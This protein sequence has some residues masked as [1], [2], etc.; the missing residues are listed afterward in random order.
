MKNSLQP[1]WKDAP[2]PAGWSIDAAPRLRLALLFLAFAVPVCFTA[3]RLVWLQVMIPDRFLTTWIRTHESFE[4]IPASDGR[5]LARDGE[6]LAFDQPLYSIRVH[7]RWIEEPPNAVWLKARARETLSKSDRKNPE[8]VAEAQQQILEQRQRM[9]QTLSEL[10]GVSPAELSDKRSQVQARIEQ[11]AQQVNER[12]QQKK[13]VRRTSAGESAWRRI[14]HELS[15][16]PERENDNWIIVSEELQSHVIL[17]QVPVDQIATIEAQP[18]RFPGVEIESTSERVYPQGALAAHLIGW[19]SAVDASEIERRKL[20]FPQGDPLALEIGDRFGRSGVERT[21]DSQLRGV[22]GLKRVVRNYAGEIVETEV[23]TPPRNGV[24]LTLSIDAALQKQAE[25][26]L[27]LSL[28]ASPDHAQMPDSGLRIPPQAPRA[29]SIVVLDLRQGETWIAASAPSF[30]LAA[31]QHPTQ[32]QWKSWND[33]PSHPFVSRVTQAAVPPGSIFQIVT[34][35]AGLDNRLISPLS[36]FRCQGYLNEPTLDRCKHFLTTGHGHGDINLSMALAQSCHVYFFDLAQRMGPIPIE[37]WARQ[38]GFG[39]PTGI[40]VGGEKPGHVPTTIQATRRARQNSGTVKQLAI[41]QSDLTA[42]PLQVAKLMA[43]LGNGGHEITPRV[44][45]GQQGPGEVSSE[46]ELVKAS[47]T[48]GSI[49]S[50]TITA[51]QQGLEM[52]VADPRGIAH[53][54]HVD[55]VPMAGQAGIAEVGS[56]RPPHAWY[57]GYFPVDRPRYAIVT[58]LEH[59]GSEGAHAAATLARQVVLSLVEADLLKLD[60]G[61]E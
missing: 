21:Y 52:A 39:T 30:N 32:E 59:G 11:I 54:A 2:S 4:S 12:H 3:G 61:V 33:D 46:I 38:L 47:V 50:D 53:S 31:I 41:G 60:T 15:T 34:A 55:G 28:R 58:Y 9:W 24:D 13:A 44:T 5:V 51:I 49:T 6:V 20:R 48:P 45:L 43:I 16:P 29:G 10:T 35:I 17:S 27:E 37:A 57:C 19:R 56:R 7:Y 26:L 8:R 40:D 18:S 36:Q 25:D 14:W 42:T 23:V 1:H 22:R